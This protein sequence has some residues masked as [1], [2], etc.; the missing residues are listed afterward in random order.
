MMAVDS[1]SK[2]AS[3]AQIL[4]PWVLALVLPDG[5]LSRFDRQHIAWCYAGSPATSSGR[6]DTPTGTRVDIPLGTRIDTPT[7]SRTD[8]PSL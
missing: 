4:T 2:R 7:G 5:K 3:S 6:T 8:T 1:R